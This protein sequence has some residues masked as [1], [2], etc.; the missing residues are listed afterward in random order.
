MRLKENPHPRNEAKAVAGRGQVYEGR[1]GVRLRWGTASPAS[2]PGRTL[3]CRLWRSL[4]HSDKVDSFTYPLI[5]LWETP[6][7][8]RG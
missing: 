8:A 3:P 1:A 7:K 4:G 5:R 2:R 6:M